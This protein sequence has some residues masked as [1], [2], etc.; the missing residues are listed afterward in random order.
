MACRRIV[1]PQCGQTFSY[2]NPNTFSGG[3]PGPK[4]L[5]GGAPY[6]VLAC[7]GMLLILV[8][9]SYLAAGE[10]P[11]YSHEL[12]APCSLHP[13]GVLIEIA[14]LVTIRRARFRGRCAQVMIVANWIAW[15]SIALALVF[16]GLVFREVSGGL[17]WS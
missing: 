1:A 3:D 2:G 9:L 15:L 14:V 17:P 5:P 4:P 10:D 16:V 11:F 7:V 8:P 6:L 12:P 13:L